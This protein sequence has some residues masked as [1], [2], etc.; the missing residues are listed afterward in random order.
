LD[1]L[2]ARE[3]GES[4]ESLN[5]MTVAHFRT[6]SETIANVKGVES[7][8]PVTIPLNAGL[9]LHGK[10]YK[11]IQYLG[12]EVGNDRHVRDRIRITEGQLSLR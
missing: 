1:Y 4:A 11:D 8:Y 12:L 2:R 7:V 10:K 6:L 5:K 3:A 9:Y